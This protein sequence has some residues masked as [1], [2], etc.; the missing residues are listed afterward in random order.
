[1]ESEI[2]LRRDLGDLAEELVLGVV[3]ADLGAAVALLF[4]VEQLALGD[5]ERLIDRLVE[6]G[7]PVLA[8]QMLGLVADH[9][10]AAAGNAELDMHDRRDGAGAILGALVDAHPARD[11]RVIKEL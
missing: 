10:I 8:Q 2:L 4:E 7:M 5:A 11:Q 3:A 1:E 6:I 9:E